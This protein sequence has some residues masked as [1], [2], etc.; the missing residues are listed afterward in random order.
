MYMA[1]KTTV[2]YE[3]RKIGDGR[4][5]RIFISDEMLQ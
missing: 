4:H 5:A 1:L 3:N 2:L